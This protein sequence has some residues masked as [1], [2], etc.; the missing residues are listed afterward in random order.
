[1]A[2]QMLESMAKNPR[3]TRAE[4]SDVTNAVYDGADAVM[5]SGET[6]KGKYP[7][8]TLQMMNEIIL[9]AEYYSSSGSL[10]SL[11]VQHGGSKSLFMGDGDNVAVAVAKGA[12]EASFAQDCKAII[13]L[14]DSTALPSFVGAY[15]PDCPIV[16]FCPNS[17]MAR[18]LILTRGIYPVVGLQHITDGHEKVMSAMKETQRMGFISKGDSVVTIYMDEDGAHF[19]LSKAP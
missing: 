3:P 10:G 17:K 5:T 9:S 15:R 6:A 18:Q 14:A 13:V 2:T 8:E 16:T 19:K 7:S 12:V 1:V 11:Y 4:V